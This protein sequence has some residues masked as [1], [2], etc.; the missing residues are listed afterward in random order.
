MP[1]MAVSGCR[2]SGQVWD[3][4]IAR[5]ADQRATGRTFPPP[6]GRPGSGLSAH[7]MRAVG[8]ELLQTAA[9]TTDI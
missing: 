2:V 3:A 8:L 1:C 9:H 6:Q 4:Q 7:I 5:A